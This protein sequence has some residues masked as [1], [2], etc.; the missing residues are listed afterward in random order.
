[1]RGDDPYAASC[2]DAPSLPDALRPVSHRGRPCTE[3]HP[4]R[5]YTAAVL[6]GLSPAP[7]A[8][9]R[10]R[11]LG[12]A[13][14]VTAVTS[15]RLLSRCRRRR[16]G[17]D[18]AARHIA[19]AQADAATLGLKNVRFMQGDILA[20]DPKELGEF[21]Y[22]TPTACILG[23]AAGG[24]GC[25]RCAN[26][27]WHARR[28]A[29]ISYNVLPGW[30]VHSILRDFMMFHTHEQTDPRER[31]RGNA[32]EALT[33]VPR[34]WQRRG[35]GQMLRF[36]ASMPRCFQNHLRFARRVVRL[37]SFTMRLPQQHAGLLLQVR[38]PHPRKMDWKVPG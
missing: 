28:V 1:M 32:R 13:P 24:I 19:T 37:C 6:L 34:A 10:C 20:L 25:C 35:S 29:F 8:V 9:D 21:D 18:L 36:V 12:S 33:P 3:S 17:I 15:C 27:T 5:L 31:L 7:A 38:R 23:A 16:L 2:V 30:R 4:S 14:A 11:V 22:I 26:G